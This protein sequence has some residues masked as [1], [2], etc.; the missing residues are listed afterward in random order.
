MVY[1]NIRYTKV[2]AEASNEDQTITVNGVLVKSGEASGKIPLYIGLN[3]V[4]VKVTSP[5]G[6]NSRTY[7]IDIARQLAQSSYQPPSQPALSGNADLSDLILHGAMFESPT[8]FSSSDTEYLVVMDPESNGIV[9][10]PT[11]S[12]DGA[13]ITVNGMP[14]ISGTPSDPIVITE[15][16]VQ[17]DIVV[18]AEDGTTKT[19]ILMVIR[20]DFPSSDAF[21]LDL[22]LSYG[23]TIIDLQEFSPM[24]NE[25]IYA[26]EML[27][28]LDTITVIPTASDDGAQITVN[29]V[30]VDSG[31]PSAPIEVGENGVQLDILVTAED[32]TM[33]TYILNIYPYGYS[34]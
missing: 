10:T 11:A 5:D 3:T 31:S 24:V 18:T 1:D 23:G 12:D 21:L 27:P 19:Y 20:V 7:V 13:R 14:V 30:P 25:Y 16:E 6:M 32:G 33:R 22:A 15:D 29:G 17:V 2:I 34:H 26:L 4:R 9:V 8:Q 28:E